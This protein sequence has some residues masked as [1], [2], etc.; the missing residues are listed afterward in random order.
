M[1]PLPS[2]SD[3]RCGTNAG[4]YRHYNAGEQTCQPCRDARQQLGAD[5]NAARQ[6]AAARLAAEHPDRWR[7]LYVE[8]CER[9]GLNAQKGGR[10]TSSAAFR[11]GK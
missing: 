9:R 4:Y 3:P 10:S 2:T 5:R 6:R 11:V 7:E 1:S 8:E